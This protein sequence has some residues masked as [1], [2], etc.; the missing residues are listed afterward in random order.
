[1]NA[2]SPVNAKNMAPLKNVASMLVLV[3]TLSGRAQHLPG[4]GAMYGRS[5]LG[6]SV[7]TASA[8]NGYQGV[9]VEAKRVWT[10]KKFLQAILLELGVRTPPRTAADMVDEIAEHLIISRRVLFVDEADVLVD[11][12]YASV[13][14][15]LYES[16]KTPIVLVGE[17]E[18]PDKLKKIERLHNRVLSWV[19]AQ[20]CDMEDAAHLRKLY[21]DKVQIADDLL[22]RI[23]AAVRGGAR[24]ICVNLSR[25]QE[26]ALLRGLTA[27]DLAWWESLH[28][29]FFT[30][31][32]PRDGR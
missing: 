4:I 32:A 24:R 9:L 17:D 1:M 5:G 14:L 10:Q 31:D 23:R 15:D 6:K 7:A 26:E 30:G 27:V 2:V 13:I 22:D 19:P 3:E 12:G 20:P 28:L 21:C 29:D 18:L 8:A 11:R 25:V 16:T